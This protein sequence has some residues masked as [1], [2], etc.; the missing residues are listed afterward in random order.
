LSFRFCT[1]SQLY[2]RATATSMVYA[3]SARV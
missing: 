1:T 3:K 2:T